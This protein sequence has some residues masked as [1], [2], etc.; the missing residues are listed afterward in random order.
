MTDQTRQTAASSEQTR[1]KPAKC[2]V[3]DLDD[4]IWEGTLLE[5]PI[6]SLRPGLLEIIKE[7]D[8][9]GILHSVASK[10]DRAQALEMLQRFG[11]VDYL[12]YP[13]IG[14]GEKSRSIATIA[15]RLNI[16]IDSIIFIDDQRFEREEVSFVHPQVW[17]VDPSDISDL[18]ADQR[19][20]TCTLSHESR[21][22]RLLYQA[23]MIRREKEE[24]FTGTS[25]EFLATLDMKLTIC[26]ARAED[27]QRAVELTERTNQLN[28]TGSTYSYE[29]LDF[30]RMSSSHILLMAYLQD[31][32]GD[33]GA[34][35]LAL[36]ERQPRLLTI[37]LL[38]MSC[39]VLS[40]GVG[41]ILPLYFM[42]LAR[43][44]QCLLKADFRITDR[45]RIMYVTYRLAGFREEERNGDSVVLTHDLN[46][47]PVY[48]YYLDIQ[49][50]H[51]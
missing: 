47:I 45:N 13:Q 33:Y 38:L 31:K 6:R 11:L 8:S 17:C 16:G 7:L 41:M 40:R 30:L 9:R 46:T 49:I 19:L 39:R 27:L 29:Q 37:K 1:I 12:L 14:W 28:S 43:K 50:I 2:I 36:A 44:E 5:G 18:L 23:E 42:N 35:G 10:N 3:W 22:R 25:E 48:P 15:S 51:R 21:T 32:Y 20:I 24:Q 34:I 26:P 4:T